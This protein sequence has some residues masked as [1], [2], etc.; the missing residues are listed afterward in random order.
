MNSA[1]TASATAQRAA[2]TPADP[3]A[4]K[5]A[6]SVSASSKSCSVTSVRHGR[7]N[8]QPARADRVR[9]GDPS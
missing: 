6:A 3:A 2:T 7:E 9:L 1:V 8:D 5:A 4:R